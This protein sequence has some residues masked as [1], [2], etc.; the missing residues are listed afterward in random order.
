M[1]WKLLGGVVALG[2]AYMALDFFGDARHAAGVAEERNRW[3]EQRVSDVQHDADRRVANA[4]R[5][6]AAVAASA[7][8]MAGLVTLFLQSEQ[9]VSDYAKTPAGAVMCRDAARVHAIDAF[10][11]SLFT[12]S[13]A[14]TLN[15]KPVYPDITTPAG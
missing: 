13:T 12:P 2:I 11:Q 6:T 9:S 3:Q 1:L 8:R 14:A 10:D 4:E 7:E 5:G 15:G